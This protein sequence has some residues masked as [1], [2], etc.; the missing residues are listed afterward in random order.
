MQWGGAD[1]YKLHASEQAGAYGPQGASPGCQCTSPTSCTPGLRKA[2]G[3]RSDGSGG[4]P[5]VG[6]V[7]NYT[8]AAQVDI[9]EFSLKDIKG[10]EKDMEGYIGYERIFKYIF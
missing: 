9:W 4:G 5:G 10:H 6:G 3:R 2:T 1:R 7:T 8:I